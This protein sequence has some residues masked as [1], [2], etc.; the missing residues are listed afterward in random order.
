MGLLDCLDGVANLC[1]DA[2]GDKEG[3][4]SFPSGHASCAWATMLTLTVYCCFT[5]SARSISFE[6]P[7]QLQLQ[8]AVRQKNLPHESLLFTTTAS[9]VDSVTRSKEIGTTTVTFWVE[10]LSA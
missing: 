5:L 3:R 9:G 1:T 6:C 10:V 8:A 7:K 4:R 2:A